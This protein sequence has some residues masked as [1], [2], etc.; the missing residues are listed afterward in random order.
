MRPILIHH[1]DD[2]G[3]CAGAIVVRELCNVFNRPNADTIFEY[4]HGYKLMVSDEIIMDANDI[5]IVDIAIDDQILD[6]VKKIHD[7]RGDDMPKITLIDHHQSSKEL[8]RNGSA[9]PRYEIFLMFVKTFV[10]MGISGALLTYVYAQFTSSERN[11][12]PDFD[13]TEGRTHFKIFP[14]GREYRIPWAVR[15][16]DDYDVWKHEL[17]DTKYFNLGFSLEKDKNP[18]A[19]IWDNV[20]YGDERWLSRTYIEPGRLLFDYQ[21][22]LN[23][24]AMSRAFESEIDG[25]KCLC[26]NHTGN[27]MVF[28]DEIKQYPMVCLFYYDGKIHKWKYSFYSDETTGVDVEKVVKKLSDSSGGHVHAAGAVVDKFIFE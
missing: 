15:L 18:L 5:Y 3:R 7:L 19:D 11:R 8:L 22:S 24:R 12:E 25:V 21:E 4:K 13:F 28:G 9:D 27:S 2:D 1:N 14:S 26:L 16:I 20:I 6:F 17:L 23:R 10:H